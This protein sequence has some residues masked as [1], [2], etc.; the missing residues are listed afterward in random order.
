M[1]SATGR[2][3][4][5]LRSPPR[6]ASITRMK[7][8][9]GVSAR[10]A[11]CTRTKLGLA[12]SSRARAA[13]TESVRSAPPSTT[14]TRLRGTLSESHSASAMARASSSK[15]AGAAMTVSPQPARSPERRDHAK[16]VRP[17]SSTKAF[18]RSAPKRVPAPAAGMMRAVST[19]AMVAVSGDTAVVCGI[20]VRQLELPACGNLRREKQSPRSEH[21]ERGQC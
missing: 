11:S 20:G 19:T 1:V 3:G 15:S 10:A 12:V 9:F 4:T 2:V 16:S 17:A 8:S 14:A 13:E 6:R 18:G 5:T 21:S 7:T